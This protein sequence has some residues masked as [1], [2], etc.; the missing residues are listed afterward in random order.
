MSDIKR[1][2]TISVNNTLGECILWNEQ[3]QST[4]WT[5]IENAVLYEYAFDSEMLQKFALPERLCSFGFIE[6]DSRL[7]CAFASGF[8]IYDPKT[9]HIQWLS[10]PEESHIGTRFNDGRVD[11]QGRFWS[12][13]MV[14]GEGRDASGQPVLGSLYW[15]SDTEQD[16]ALSNIQIPNSLCWSPDSNTVY[17]ADSPTKEINAFDFNPDNG[18][19]S[20]KRTFAT[21]TDESSPDGSIIDAEGFLWNAQWGGA[22]V[23]R[24]SPQGENVFELPLPISQPTCMCFAGPKLDLLF[25]STARAGLS[26]AQLEEQPEAGNVFVFQTGF[27]GLEES[28]YKL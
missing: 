21:T 22:K 4:W 18:V 6:N 27:K 24:Y 8:A 26:K 20:N 5:D 14:E 19:F 13:T 9:A 15:I 23:V 2:K 28:R 7:I 3:T 11:R 17:F 10:K 25:I 1:L 16:K 12:G